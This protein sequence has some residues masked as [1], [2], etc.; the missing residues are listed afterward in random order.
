[1][2]DHVGET[3]QIIEENTTGTPVKDILWNANQI[4]TESETHLEDD[5][6]F[7]QAIVIRTYEFTASPEAFK[8]HKPS[9]Q[10]LFN[11]HYQGIEVMLWK[12]GLK[13]W[14]EVLPKVLI[15]KKKTKYRIIVAGIAQKG[16][17]FL[18]KPKTLAEIAHSK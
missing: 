16:Q 14:P 7:G 9:K 2:A 13:V 3:K 15:N 18:E 8:Q 1:M 5:K 11:S 10:E 17:T 12:D 6:G 4:N